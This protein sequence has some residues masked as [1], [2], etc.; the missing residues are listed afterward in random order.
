MQIGGG[1]GVTH[2]SLCRASAIKSF[3]ETEPVSAS[4]HHEGNARRHRGQ[5]AGQKSGGNYRR[6]Q[7]IGLAR[8]RFAQEARTW[9]SATAPTKRRREVASEFGSW[10]KSGGLS[11]A[12]WPRSEGQKFMR[13]PCANS[14]KIDILVNNAGLERRAD[15]WDTTKRLCAVLNVILKGVFFIAQHS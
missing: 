10:A 15:F 3:F 1:R 5:A 14:E 13:T 2:Y 11:N 12:M 8:Q 4:H 6:K 9:H 7:G